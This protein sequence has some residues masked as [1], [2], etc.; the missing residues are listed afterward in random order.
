M[1]NILLH[2]LEEKRKCDKIAIIIAVYMM[3]AM[4]MFEASWQFFILGNCLVW[5]MWYFCRKAIAKRFSFIMKRRSNLRHP[6]RG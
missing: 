2:L 3:V 4:L 1:H 6:Q 5:G